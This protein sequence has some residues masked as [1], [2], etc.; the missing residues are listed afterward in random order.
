MFDAISSASDLDRIGMIE[1]KMDNLDR[2]RNYLAPLGVTPA[3]HMSYANAVYEGWAPAPTNAVQQKIWD[4]A[5]TPPSK[6][7]KITYD[8]G[9]QKPVVK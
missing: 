6:P 8:K 2:F 9:K 3:T 4:E 7:I 5:H 1:F